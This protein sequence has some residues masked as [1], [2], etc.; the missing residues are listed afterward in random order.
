MVHKLALNFLQLLKRD[1][2][3]NPNKLLKDTGVLNSKDS[4]T[5]QWDTIL[6]LIKVVIYLAILNLR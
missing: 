3:G 4:T 2:E 6:S 5:W 1:I